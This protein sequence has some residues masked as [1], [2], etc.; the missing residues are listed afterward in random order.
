VSPE[1]SP[2]LDGIFVGVVGDPSEDVVQRWVN[3][4]QRRNE[5]VRFFPS[6]DR[7]DWT[8]EEAMNSALVPAQTL[9]QLVA[10]LTTSH[11]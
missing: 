10:T 11:E 5:R 1:S 9:Q 8:A 2:A 4:R 7:F 3:E 6:N